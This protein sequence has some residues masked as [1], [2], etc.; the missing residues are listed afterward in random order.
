MR[1]QPHEYWRFPIFGK[2]ETVEFI[3]NPLHPQAALTLS[4]RVPRLD[5]LI[6]SSAVLVN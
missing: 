2:S 3:P 6:I 4:L 1:S 5:W